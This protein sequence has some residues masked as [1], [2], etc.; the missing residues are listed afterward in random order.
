M[1]LSSRPKLVAE[2]LHT[3]PNNPAAS[4]PNRCSTADRTNSCAAPDAAAA[5][6][7]VAPSAISARHS[8][9]GAAGGGAPGPARGRPRGCC[10]RGCGACTG[11]GGAG[12]RGGGGGGVGGGGGGWW[13]GGGGGGV[14][15][16]G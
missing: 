11:G 4:S 3:A 12:G 10:A 5:I 16:G 7:T 14:R 15:E 9:Q 13:G 2:M 6:V 1:A 8:A